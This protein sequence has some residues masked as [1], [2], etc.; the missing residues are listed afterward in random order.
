MVG[1]AGQVLVGAAHA[2]LWVRA[3]DLL[4]SVFYVPTDQIISRSLAG[5]I[6]ITVGIFGEAPK[7][8]PRAGLSGVM[9]RRLE[10]APWPWLFLCSVVIFWYS[11]YSSVVEVFGPH[12][13]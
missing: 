3:S 12:G 11:R 7:G 8:M 13:G 4:G 5:T 2:S 1:T 6:R 9:G 10:L